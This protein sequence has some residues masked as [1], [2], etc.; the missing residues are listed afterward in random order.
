MK[1]LIKCVTIICIAGS[2]AAMAASTYSAITG[3]WHLDEGKGQKTLDVS[4]NNKPAQLGSTV[5]VDDNDPVWMARNFDNAALHFD[6]DNDYLRV[7]YAKN[8]EPKAV[9]VEAWVRSIDSSDVNSLKYIVAKSGL[10]CAY[11][12]YALYTRGGELAFYIWNGTSYIES[13]VT[14]AVWDGGW[15]HIV[16]TYDNKAVRLFVDG[17][18]VGS[19]TPE[20]LAISYASFTHKDLYIGSYDDGSVCFADDPELQGTYSN[21][22]FSGDIDSVRIWNRALSPSEISGSSISYGNAP[23]TGH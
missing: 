16:G 4:G 21:G 3:N 6:G 1:F 12:A 14:S 15:H 5:A 22:H 17:V 23:K 9:S 10:S 2:S 19:G 18:Q 11:A 13:P 7:S 20:N 8:F